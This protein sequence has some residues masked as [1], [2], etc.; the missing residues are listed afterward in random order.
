MGNNL[1]REL[2]VYLSPSQSDVEMELNGLSEGSH[3]DAATSAAVARSALE[4][5]LWAVRGVPFMASSDEERTAL[6]G[7]AAWYERV[8]I[9]DAYDN[10]APADG[11]DALTAQ[12]HGPDQL[13]LRRSVVPHWAVRV[14]QELTE[15][16]RRGLAIDGDP[17]ATVLAYAKLDLALRGAFDKL[18]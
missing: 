12:E 18:R 17:A 1:W 11:L 2:P 5:W 14:A 7:L 16:R 3:R 13:P 8:C 4:H 15:W 6:R 10:P 9:D